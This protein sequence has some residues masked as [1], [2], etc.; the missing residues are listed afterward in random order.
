[1]G[2]ICDDTDALQKTINQHEK[3][4]KKIA[5]QYIKEE[6]EKIPNSWSDDKKIMR[7]MQ[8]AQAQQQAEEIEFIEIASLFVD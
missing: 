7:V 4:T 8:I 5:D 3:N 2:S 1:M 6:M